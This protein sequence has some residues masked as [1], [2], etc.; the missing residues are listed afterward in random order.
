MSRV[1]IKICGLTTAA[2]VEA[3]VDAGVDAI[4][5]VLSPSPRQ[6]DTLQAKKL[7]A[8]LPPWVASV[9][10]TRQPSRGFAEQVLADLAPDWWQSDRDDL[11]GQTLPQGTRALAVVREGDQTTTLP[12]WF[13]Y[14]GIQSGHGATVDWRVAT[15][16]ARRG[17][18]ILA[19]GLD[20][21]NVGEAIRIVGPYGVD[22]S[23]GVEASRGI[24]DAG[25]IRE[26]VAAVRRAEQWHDQESKQELEQNK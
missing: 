1:R 4:G 12:D 5:L 16:L 3:A 22:V 7:I 23:S 6:L 13:V 15:T 17:R 8:S 21:A 9:V 10:V 14:E 25:L 20:P 19:G 18:L 24:K 26:F 2:A 11:R